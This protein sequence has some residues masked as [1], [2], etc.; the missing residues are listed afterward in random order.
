MPVNS[1]EA[2][3]WYSLAAAQNV[4]N[5]IEALPELTKE[6]TRAQ[7][8]EG[9]RRAADFVPREEHVSQTEEPAALDKLIM[10]CAG[11][12]TRLIERLEAFE[13]RLKVR[14]EALKVDIGKSTTGYDG[15]WVSGELHPYDGVEIDDDI[16]LIVDVLDDKG[17]V[18][19]KNSYVFLR[20]NFFGFES[21]MIMIAV[22]TDDVSKLRIYP[23]KC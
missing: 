2:Y 19:N 20:E 14:L 7:I 5:S 18:A 15:V 6:M 10:R 1:I 3:K 4:D 11:D 9:Q 23:K 8:A 16:E 22:S 12:F 21:F 17:R 13:D